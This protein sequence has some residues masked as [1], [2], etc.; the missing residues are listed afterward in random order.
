MQAPI[1]HILPLTTIVR[2]RLLP[3][4]G[5][6]TARLNQ[7]VGPTEVVAQATWARE[8]VLLDVSGSLHLAPSVADGLI[9]CK[10]GDTLPAGAEVATGRGLFPKSIR[11]PKPGRVVAAGGGQVLLETG[12]T[13][14][15]LRAGMPGIVIQ[16]IP[17]RGVVIQASGS[18][19]QGVWG[20][21]RIETGLLV[22][23]AETADG[24]LSAGRLDVS[25]RGSIILGGMCKD[26]ESLQAAAELPVRGLILSSLNPSLIPLASQAR[27]PIMLTDGFGALPMNS[28]AYR[29]LSTNVQR[30]LTLNADAYDRYTGTRP[31]AIIPLPVSQEPAQPHDTGAFAPG[32][33][34]R[35]RR[36]PALG[37][38]GSI[39]NLR[40][41]H[42]LLT[43]GLRAPAAEV[44]MESG[45][46]VLV[47]LV[48]L[49]VVG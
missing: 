24:V 3:V 10:V 42:T 28:S 25:M 32:Q 14:I 7:K 23:L 30:E 40:P 1:L 37:G 44:K 29:L 9:R 45:E 2:E 26:A 39:V 46:M 43:S 11:T 13:N 20:N 12:E 48:N 16:I 18:L 15:Q 31:E 33:T 4:A 22:N 49:E 17:E 34:V 35:M 38:I 19:I 8:H 41:G 47:P 27:F 21:G 36:P 6:V 5:T